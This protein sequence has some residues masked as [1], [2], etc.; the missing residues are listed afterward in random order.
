M[1]YHGRIEKCIEKTYG[2]P[3]NHLVFQELVRTVRDSEM[4]FTAGNGGSSALASHFA[5]D[6]HKKCRTPA[7]CLT[8]SVPKL[9]AYSNDFDYDTALSRQ[10]GQFGRLSSSALVVISGSGDSRNILSL[11]QVAKRRSMAVYGIFAMGGGEAARLLE[12]CGGVILVETGR[13]DVAEDVTSIICHDLTERIE[14]HDLEGGRRPG[15]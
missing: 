3:R 5:Q 14:I 12:G 6:V 10:L 15:S 9:T 8:D 11:I 4:L 1:D 13:W 2:D 7:I